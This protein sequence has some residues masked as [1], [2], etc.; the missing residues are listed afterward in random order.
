MITWLLVHSP[1]LGPGSW[2]AV[3]AQL[4]AAGERVRVPDLRD[5]LAA[6]QDLVER[7]V[8]LAAADPLGGPVILAGHSGAGP[9]LPAV[10]A[11]LAEQGSEVIATVFVDAGMPHPGNPR[12]ATLP[13]ALVGHLESLTADG[14]VPPWPRWW[15]PEELAELLPDPDLRAELESDC[16]R[17]P[18]A[19]FDEVLPSGPD[20]VGGYVQLSDAYADA[21]AAAAELGWAVARLEADHLAPLTRPRDV[22]LTMRSVTDDISPARNAARAHVAAFNRAVRGGDWPA[23]STR[24]AGDATMRFTNV[25][26]GPFHGRAAIERGY[27]EQ[28]PDDTMTIR[29]L[30]ETDEDTVQIGFEWDA[31]GA[32]TM[33]LRRRDG[34]VSE[35]TITFG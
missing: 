13:P 21:A 18:A 14:W 34:Q 11:A 9:L 5:A 22:A 33:L 3:A 12:R 23:F 15:A 32:G 1:L 17:L 35:L 25:P 2:K 19:L 26:A 28:P 10:A 4:T 31:G 7:Q 16:P 8:A 6:G 20:V 30:H 24:F 27:A 29:A